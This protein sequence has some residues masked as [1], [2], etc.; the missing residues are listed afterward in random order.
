ML[1]LPLPSSITSWLVNSQDPEPVQGSSSVEKPSTDKDTYPPSGVLGATHRTQRSDPLRRFSNYHVEENSGEFSR[2]KH[3]HHHHHLGPISWKKLTTLF[4]PHL[5]ISESSPTYR[6]LPIFSGIVVPFSILLD[7]PSLS[8]HWYVRTGPNSETIET[9]PNPR[10]LNVAMAVSMAFALFACICLVIRFTERAVKLMTILAIISLTAH[11]VISIIAVTA[12]GIGHR[13]DDGFTYGQS[14]WMA[15]CATFSSTV[16]NVTLLIDYAW[17][18]NFSKSGSGLTHKQRSLVIIV[19]VL[20]CYIALGALVLSV[21][22]KLN[23]IDALYLAVVSIET[24]G[25]GDLHPSSTASRVVIC[26]YITFGILNLALAVALSREAVLEAVAINLQKRIRGIRTRDRERRINHRWR[27][28]VKWRLRAKRLPI[29]VEEERNDDEWWK[30]FCLRSRNDTTWKYTHGGPRHKR[31]NVEALSLAQLEAAAMEAGAPLASLL[32]PNFRL[33]DEDNAAGGWHPSEPVGGGGGTG[34]SPL[35]HIRLGR[36]LAL[37]GNFA[38]AMGHGEHVDHI[39]TEEEEDSYDDHEDSGS[40]HGVPL[41]YTMT[42]DPDVFDATV[43]AEEETAFYARLSAAFLLFFMFWLV[44]SAI[45]MKTEGWRFGTAVYFCFVAFTTVG[46]GDLSP[47][48]PAGR[49]IFVVWALLG[50]ATMTILISIL[51]EAY[52][53]NYKSA[54]RPQGQ[55]P[56]LS[57]YINEDN[58]RQRFHDSRTMVGTSLNFTPTTNQEHPASPIS[59][60]SPLTFTPRGQKFST[61][62]PNGTDI[63]RNNSFIEQDFATP[64]SAGTSTTLLSPAPIRHNTRTNTINTS[65]PEHYELGRSIK[66]KLHA[67][68]HHILER[69]QRARTVVAAGRK[70]N[71]HKSEPDG[72]GKHGNRKVEILLSNIER[73]WTMIINLPIHEIQGLAPKFTTYSDL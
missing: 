28:A 15:L 50:V 56:L 57:P 43:E 8:G 24:I 60:N 48:T 40:Y 31:L 30:A 32:P 11:D 51:T 58:S 64:P 53:I 65:N 68:P 6:I 39:H 49:S 52:S 20:L 67:L 62:A 73:I 27:G 14:F 2:P 72:D 59:P 22:M 35:T 70:E 17:T 23:F 10:L 66:G 71:I 46:Y 69:V 21:M 9:R 34:G 45:F 63:L 1:N 12:F 4:H 7:I 26:F 44:G 16:T 61:T 41:T 18:K 42:M 36:M 55:Q 33:S 37:L 29:W 19:I 3:E 54:I 47:S 25:F 5:V 38:L 13:D